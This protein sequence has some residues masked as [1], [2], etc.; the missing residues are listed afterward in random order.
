MPTRRIGNIPSNNPNI[1]KDKDHEPLIDMVLPP[2]LYEHVCKAC[3]R[4]ITFR[5]NPPV[6]IKKK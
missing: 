3:G 5:I 4:I 2:G 1:C 6:H